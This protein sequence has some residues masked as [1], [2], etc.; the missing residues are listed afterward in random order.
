MRNGL[1]AVQP[2]VRHWERR[3]LE[4]EIEIAIEIDGLGGSA[5][6]GGSPGSEGVSPSP[7]SV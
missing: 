2:E 6:P 5:D 4:I 3:R 1:A 7:N